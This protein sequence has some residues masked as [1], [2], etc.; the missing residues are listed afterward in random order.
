MTPYEYEIRLI[1]MNQDSI[2]LDIPSNINLYEIDLDSTNFDLGFFFDIEIV[3]QNRPIF[4]GSVGNNI[5]SINI[6]NWRWGIQTITI[7]II[8]NFLLN[9]KLEKWI[10]TNMDLKLTIYGYTLDAKVD[11]NDQ[12]EL[13]DDFK[14][15]W[16]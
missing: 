1:T 8:P 10:I 13:G 14:G 6:M 16:I 15:D 3:S 9:E 7:R 4:I 5:K 12:K 11:F 2:T